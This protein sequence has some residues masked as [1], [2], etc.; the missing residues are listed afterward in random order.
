MTCSVATDVYYVTDCKWW[1]LELWTAIIFMSWCQWYDI[2]FDSLHC[3][4]R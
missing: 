1:G 4:S 2:E 3:W